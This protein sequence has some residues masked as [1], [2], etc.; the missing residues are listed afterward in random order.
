MATTKPKV[1]FVLTSHNVMGNTDKPTGWY[2]PEFAHPYEVLSPYAEIVVASPAGGEAPIDQGSVQMFKDE[3]SV[4]F[5]NTK[6]KLWKNTEKLSQFTGKAK[7]FSAVFYVGGHGPMWDIYNDAN[8]LQIIREFYESGKVVAA[9]CHGSAALVKAKLSDGTP[10][11]AGA[12]VTGFSN[13]EED[14]VGL[15]PAMP[16]M[17]ETELNKISGG[18]YLKAADPWAEKVVV[19]KGGRLITGQNPASA[20]GTG[21]AILKAIGRK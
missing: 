6:S 3:V 8:S 13:A 2:L 17:L 10:L 11:I 7:Y 1:L 18:K 16:F 19:S 21:K 20:E 15:S 9:V 14:A 5:L 12:D 4:S